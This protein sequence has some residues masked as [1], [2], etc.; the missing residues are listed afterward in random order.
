MNIEK[1]TIKEIKKIRKTFS[2]IKDRC[3]N[4]KTQKSHLYY[5]KGI[6]N[7]LTFELLCLLYLYDKA[8]L[9]KKPSIDRIN[10]DKNY[11][12][13]NCQWI[14]HSINSGKDLKKVTLQFDLNG[15][16]IREWESQ[17]TVVIN[18]KLSQSSLSQCIHNKRKSCGGFIWKLG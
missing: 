17:Q 2:G 7:Y 6:K 8:Y 12:L 15:N 18:L 4:S 5:E 14:E 16:F 3:N 10:S 13:E 11:V 1:L 9:M